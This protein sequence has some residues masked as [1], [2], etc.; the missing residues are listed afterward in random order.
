[1]NVFGTQ[2]PVYDDRMRFFFIRLFMKFGMKNP[3][4]EKKDVFSPED[5]KEKAREIRAI[6]SKCDHYLLHLRYLVGDLGALWQN[7]IQTALTAELGSIRNSLADYSDLLEEYAA[8]ADY[9][10][11]QLASDPALVKKFA[12]VS[13][14]EGE[15]VP[16]AFSTAPELKHLRENEGADIPFGLPGMRAE[17]K[18]S[19]A[20]MIGAFILKLGL[21][22]S[23]KDSKTQRLIQNLKYNALELRSAI[24]QYN[25]NVSKMKYIIESMTKLWENAYQSNLIEELENMESPV[26]DFSN[27]IDELATLMDMAAQE[28]DTRKID[29]DKASVLDGESGPVTIELSSIPYLRRRIDLKAY[30][31]YFERTQVG[32]STVVTA[33]R[34]NAEYMYNVYED[35]IEIVKY[36]GLRRTLEL[37][38]ELDGLPVTHIGLDC[39]AMAWRVRFISI[40]IP[41]S[42]TTIYHGAFRGCSYI[43]EVNLPKSLKYIGNYAFAFIRDLERIAIPEG[44][45]ALGMGAFRNC[46]GLKEIVIPASVLRIGNDCFYTCKSLERAVIGDGVVNIEDWAFRQCEHLS[47]V[48]ISKSVVNIGESA[49]YDDVLLMRLDIPENVEK[50][51]DNAFYH[52]RGM[53]LGVHIGSAADRYARAFHHK[54]EFI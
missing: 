16:Y 13:E 19:V 28:L 21:R 40:T 26:K 14:Q 20:E 5:M 8:L 35:H 18:K 4:E 3:Y 1:M 12:Q 36:I 2:A 15:P 17:P 54:Y 23:D 37:P 9:V 51:G 27:I 6:R 50:I 45:V 53:T 29:V 11:L 47:S 25:F 43:R 10:A 49:F 46:E 42:V 30:D 39:F 7:K 44:V 24:S 22:K 38:R 31:P 48:V 33:S 52:R 34:K 32:V 41:E